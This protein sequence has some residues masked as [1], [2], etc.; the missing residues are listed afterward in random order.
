MSGDAG[1]DRHRR[2]RR[3]L[4]GP[5]I[6]V[7]RRAPARQRSSLGPP[8]LSRHRRAGFRPAGRGQFPTPPHRTRPACSPC[9]HRVTRLRC[10]AQP[11][12]ASP[13]G[14]ADSRHA[15]SRRHCGS[16]PPRRA[17]LRCPVLLHRASPGGGTD[18]HHAPAAAPRTAP[19]WRLPR[20]A[21]T[22]ATPPPGPAAALRN[23]AP[24]GPAA[25]P[26]PAPPAVPT[27]PPPVPPPTP[28]TGP[29][30]AERRTFQAFRGC[31]RPRCGGSSPR[32]PHRAPTWTHLRD[33]RK[34]ATRRSGA[35]A[36]RVDCGEKWGTVVPSGA[37]GSP[38]AGTGRGANRI[39]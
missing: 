7:D 1:S 23:V 30:A 10:P 34:R 32:S 28:T 27:S 24:P 33:L 31:G 12:R 8:R 11:H 16:P 18:S 5:L 39:R 13:G 15:L 6:T 38:R 2:S 4:R 3:R 14:G 36:R 21:P 29:H 20:V 17:P 26:H 37:E 35:A 19:P 22:P 25:A 9:F